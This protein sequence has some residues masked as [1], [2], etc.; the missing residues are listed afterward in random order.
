MKTSLARIFVQHPFC[1][2]C[3]LPMKKKIM[4]EVANIKNVTLYSSKSLVVFNFNN[5]NQVAQVLNTL[6]D[7]GHPQKGDRISLENSI[8]PLC[9]CSIENNITHNTHYAISNNSF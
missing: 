9:R 4:A 2:S 8:P 7:L 5:V 3:V 1:S 6:M